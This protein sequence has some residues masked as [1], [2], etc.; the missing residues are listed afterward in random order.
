MGHIDKVTQMAT[1][2]HTHTRS[3]QVST[4][5]K[6]DEARPLSRCTPSVPR[7]RLGSREARGSLGGGSGPGS[8]VRC[9]VVGSQRGDDAGAAM[10]YCRDMHS[11]RIPNMS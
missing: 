5:H 1:F 6:A 11:P 9:M 2:R 3:S 10:Y 7:L 4:S 8:A